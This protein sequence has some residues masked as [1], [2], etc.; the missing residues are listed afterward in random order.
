MKSDP[1]KKYILSYMTSVFKLL[2]LLLLVSENVSAQAPAETIPEFNFFS[3]GKNLFT[4]KELPPGKMLFFI[5]FDSDCDHC[6]HAIQYLDRHYKDFKKTAIYL[7]TLDDKEKIRRFMSKY[8]STLYTR[9]NVTILQDPKYDFINKFRPRKYPALFLYSEK[10]ELMLYEDNEQN[11]FRFSK[12]L[13]TA[14]K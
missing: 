11:L 6:Q 13:N 2:L 8:G 14:S 7:I 9:K 12:R 3:L 1:L 4:N 5:F 10:R